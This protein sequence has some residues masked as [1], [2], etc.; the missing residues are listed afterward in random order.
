MLARFHHRLDSIAFVA[1]I[2]VT[3]VADIDA[4]SHLR[5]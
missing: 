2:V 5:C 3:A 1:L 4:V